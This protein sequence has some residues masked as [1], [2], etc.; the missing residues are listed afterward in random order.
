MKRI[1]SSPNLLPVLAGLFLV[2]S[3]SNCKKDKN[4]PAVVCYLNRILTEGGGVQTYS[5]DAQNRVVRK[6]Y[7]GGTYTT[8]AYD[9]D[10]IVTLSYSAN[11]GVTGQTDY[12]LNSAG[13]IDH[14]ERPNDFT[15]D[16]FYDADGYVQ[17]YILHDLLN[18]GT[19]Q[20]EYQI[21]GGNIITL[22]GTRSSD[23][24]EYQ[25]V[26]DYYTDK[27]DKGGYFNFHDGFSSLSA[28]PYGKANRNLP[29][30]ST[31]TNNDG[32]TYIEEFEYTFTPEG[33]VSAVT[34]AAQ[35]NSNTP[36]ESVVRYEYECR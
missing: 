23:G 22:T 14:F 29:R 4:D 13:N 33:Y 17:T 16:I 12:E 15:V 5:Y 27:E 3:T 7:S 31:S 11:G 35:W 2:L 10:R 26:Y 34:I 18:G 21:V 20:Q 30:K 19:L 1:L 8:Y 28:L 24:L 32:N 9:P 6:D 25:I 36:D